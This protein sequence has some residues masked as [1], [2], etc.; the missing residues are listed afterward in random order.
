V[1]T[2]PDLAGLRDLSG[3]E[4]RAFVAMAGRLGA[5]PDDIA[6]VVGFETGPAT[7]FS[8]A[9]RNP[10]SGCT[11]LIQFCRDTAIG[12]GT[13]LDELATMSFTEQLV[14]VERYF[15]RFQG[16]LTS[17]ESTY[18]AVFWPAA[19]SKADD[20]VIAEQ[21]TLAYSQNPAFDRQ[22]RGYFTRGDVVAEIRA[23]AAVPRGR[24]DV[25]GGFSFDL[26]S[27]ILLGA[28]AGAGVAWYSQSDAWGARS[29]RDGR[30]RL[31]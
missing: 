15:K 2:L 20:F 17:L 24:I 29:R 1:T 21:G 19:M 9:A 10:A 28:V 5:N 8:P 22:G 11:G 3:G 25:P 7:P 23:Y 4:K 26:G 30:A 31:W 27:I 12:L 16:R 6:Y 13:T 18:L 14:Y